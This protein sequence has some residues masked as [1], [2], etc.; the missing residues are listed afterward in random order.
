[1]YMKIFGYVL[2]LYET[3]IKI[4]SKYIFVDYLCT[5]DKEGCLWEKNILKNL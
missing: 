1:M 2:T 4:Q 3:N 5:F